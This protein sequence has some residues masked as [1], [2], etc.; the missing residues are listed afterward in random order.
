M[1]FPEFK[2]IIKTRFPE[3]TETQYSRFEAME[4]LYGEWNS[5]VNVISRKD[6]GCLYEHHVLHSLAIAAYLKENRGEIYGSMSADG[7]NRILDIGTGGG[8]PGI[9]L[10]VMFPGSHFTLCDSVGKKITVAENI[11]EALELNN[12]DTVNSR[13]ESLQGKF[14]FVVSRAV[15]PLDKLYQWTRNRYTKGLIC[16]KGG[17]INEEIS[18]TATRYGLCEKNIST[19]K[20][21]NW[22]EDEYYKGKFVIH[23]GK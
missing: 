10:A 9:P 3:L 15:A 23:I 13:G 17:D 7:G 8:F 5:K 21:D 11:A 18:L 12:I 16:L 14:D 2:D 6:I 20:I 1:T 4:K 22:L 19:W